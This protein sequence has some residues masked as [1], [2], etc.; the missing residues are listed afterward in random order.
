MSI[1]T[2]S[3]QVATLTRYRF[4]AAGSE[5]SVS[6]VDAN[7]AVLAYTVGMEQV[8][9]NGVMLVRG[10]DYT[11]SSGTSI[12]ALTALAA[13][14]IVEVLTFSP[15]TITNAVDQTLVDAKGDILVGTGDNVITRLGVGS[16]NALLV[17]DS[18]QTSGVKW[19]ATLS[20]LTLTAPVIT[21]GQSTPTFTTNAYT[22][23]SGD[24]GLALLASNGAT[25]GTINIPTNASVPFAIGTQISVINVGS[26]LITIQATTSGTTTVNSTGATATAPKL[27]A[28][29]SAATLWKTATD[30]W[31]VFGDVA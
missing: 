18:S 30:T 7:G 1:S 10:S 17:A 2:A 16:N 12:T 9:L 20:G 19:A 11:A 6:G 27:R 23:V 24:S 4:V 8:Y 15:F 31:Y 13:N 21:Q 22:L 29:F 25:A 3:S 26:G 14:D 28:Q 5:T